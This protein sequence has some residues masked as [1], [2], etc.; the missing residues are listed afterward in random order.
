MTPL[1]TRRLVL[2]PLNEGDLDWV[3]QEAGRLEV[4]RWLTKV[5]HPYRRADAEAF[6]ASVMAGGLG[7]LWVITRDGAPCGIISVGDELGYWIAQ[8]VWGEGIATE[9]AGAVIAHAFANPARAEIRSGHF[10][11]NHASRHVLRKLGFADAGPRTLT[12]LALG[13][14]VR[15][16]AMVLTRE[17]WQARPA[18]LSYRDLGP[19][20]A[21]DLHR[22][23]TPWAVTRQLGSWPWPAD[24]AFTAT[25]SAPFAGEGFVWGV[26]EA[27]RLVGTV[28]L[29]ARDGLPL[30]GY[31]FDLATAG[32]GLATRAARE[33]LHHGFAT[34]GWSE[35]R[36]DTWHDNRASGRVL[37]KL[38]FTHWRTGYEPSRARAVP[39]LTHSYRLA[40]TD[41]QRLSNRAH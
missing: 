32:R 5:A 28:G 13:R 12:S 33:A 38:G 29:T 16:R 25:R 19:D 9:A 10:E 6:Y 24:P 36:A 21:A 41:W 14:E 1:S 8:N 30:L 31:M 2:R 39:T 7:D 4:S 27:G 22:I 20:D 26:F 15:S 23:V 40:R 17:A 11:D 18:P 37:A 3:T 34:W 35:V